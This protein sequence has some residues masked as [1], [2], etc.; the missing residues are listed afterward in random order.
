MTTAKAFLGVIGLA[1]AAFGLWVL[2][3]EAVDLPAGIAVQ[4]WLFFGG[5]L[6]LTGA[7]VVP[8]AI[9]PKSSPSIALALVRLIS[10][11]VNSGL[12]IVDVMVAAELALQGAEFY[13]AAGWFFSFGGVAAM[14]ALASF[15]TAAEV[16][17]VGDVAPEEP[18]SVGS[19]V[20][21]QT[22]LGL[23]Y[24]AAYGSL[25]VLFFA[26][27]SLR[28]VSIAA[29]ESGTFSGWRGV[30]EAMIS[31][32]YEAVLYGAVIAIL[33]FVVAVGSGAPALM[34]AAKLSSAAAARSPL[35]P[36]EREFIEG[37]K[38]K[39]LTFIESISGSS[40]SVRVTYILTIFLFFSI[41]IT[42]FVW[43][44]FLD[45][46]TPSDEVLAA[47]TPPDGW[48]IYVDDIGVS[49]VLLI[50]TLIL[51]YGAAIMHLG[52]RWPAFGLYSYLQDNQNFEQKLSEQLD[53]DL[54]LRRVVMSD[55]FDPMQYLMRL[56][57]SVA[58]VFTVIGVLVGAANLAF[59]WMDQ[60]HYGAISAD[61]VVTID[62]WSGAEYL[63]TLEEVQGV[64]L[65]CREFD[66]GVELSYVLELPAASAATAS[67]SAISWNNPR[68]MQRGYQRD[69][70][71]WT[72]LDAVLRRLGVPIVEATAQNVAPRFRDQ[73]REDDCISGLRAALDLERA[74]Q[75]MA[76]M[77]ASPP[78]AV[79][80]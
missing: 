29:L 73:Y 15:T 62:Y 35:S 68:E 78:A 65:R 74:Q 2:H 47:R 18:A 30:I 38:G 31:H 71:A 32:S 52:I 4:P 45:F 42:L 8:A 21:R 20:R 46:S 41:I 57:V 56:H 53:F 76:L 27:A 33:M 63:T 1:L 59:Y 17:Q 61:G 13:V 60:R 26:G 22:S 66:D 64:R 9:L 44:S 67:F 5:Y 39:I 12:A 50:F 75:V 48:S 51:W 10:A 40:A 58:H 79:A 6:V 72:E 7:A 16:D 69:F 24:A 23:L 70:S 28:Q 11:F 55:V 34:R 25:P 77:K 80:E 19:V 43:V 54:R 14:A 3:T 36:E 37:C 49:G